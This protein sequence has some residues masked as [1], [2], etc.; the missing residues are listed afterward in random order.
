MF[1]WRP[2][3]DGRCE[4]LSIVEILSDYTYRSTSTKLPTERNKFAWVK[5]SLDFSLR[6]CSLSLTRHNDY[7]LGRP[8][9][10]VKVIWQKAPHGGPIPRLWSPQGVESCTIEFLG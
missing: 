7:I 10:E 5:L 9:Q 6:F 8:K 1:L 2:T 3:C 4:F